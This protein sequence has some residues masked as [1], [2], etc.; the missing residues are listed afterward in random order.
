[1]RF[2]SLIK[3]N[4]FTSV[5]GIS[6]LR[7]FQSA[8]SP[9]VAFV[10]G[11][12]AYLTPGFCMTVV[13]QQNSA[14]T[15]TSEVASLKGTADD[16]RYR[17]GPGDVLA[18]VVRKAPELSGAVRVDQ[19][20]MIRL[21]M[22]DGEVNAA[23]RTE[24]ELATVIAT[25]YLEYKNNPSV[26][27]FVSEFQ[28][29]PVAVIG[30]V[31]TPG[32]F[33]LQ[34]QVR[35]LELLSFAGGPSVAAGRVLNVI[36]TGGPS[37]CQHDASENEA[38]AAL[39]GLGV[40]KLNDTLKGKEEANPFVQPGDIVSL[41]EADQVFVVGYVYSPR[42]ISLKDKPITVSRAIAMAGGPQR[43]SKTSRI[44]IV[45]QTADGEKKQEI[46]VDL[47]AIAREK[48]EDITL[49]P[50]DI[51]EVPSSTGKIIL[52][53]LTGAVAPAL[54]QLPVRAMP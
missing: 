45:R 35:L 48:A 31:N 17:I 7:S 24:S 6:R 25:L 16:T 47:K 23:C 29:R 52:N 33:R 22:I 15:A 37:V 12:V 21:P 28:S 42:A 27:V 44:R 50:N 40:F 19:R 36:H 5:Y 14:P 2:A 4:D 9:L 1:M 38:V 49:L 34:R 32:Q 43:D 46:L 54:S 53:A 41:P 18:V 30:A 26:E 20:G 11:L 8:L 39:Q 10:L 3:A 51:V 13:G